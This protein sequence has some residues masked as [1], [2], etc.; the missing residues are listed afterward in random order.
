MLAGIPSLLGGDRKEFCG[1][2]RGENFRQD[3]QDKHDKQNSVQ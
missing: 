1:K 3:L 2:T